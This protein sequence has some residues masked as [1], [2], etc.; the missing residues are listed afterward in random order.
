MK[1]LI[2]KKYMK[3]LILLFALLLSFL[4]SA[5]TATSQKGTIPTTKPEDKK[6]FVVNYTTAYL[7]TTKATQKTDSRIFFNYSNIAH[8]IKM[9][10]NAKVY[11]YSQISG[12][13][14]GET[15][16]IKVLDLLDDASGEEVQL[17]VYL[18]EDLKV[19]ILF[20]DGSFAILT[21]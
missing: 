3:K 7:S 14:N 6:Q 19:K 17:S 11:N 8:K 5:Q 21:Q 1:F 16:R 13:R 18:D 15:D 2:Y 4:G 10:V 12:T 9:Y 20:N